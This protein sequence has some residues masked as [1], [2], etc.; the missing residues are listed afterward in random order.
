MQNL[1]KYLKIIIIIAFII[2]I[3]RIDFGIKNGYFESD[4]ENFKDSIGVYNK[5]A[6]VIFI[7][8][9][10]LFLFFK[11]RKQIKSK[12]PNKISPEYLK[13]TLLILFFALIIWVNFDTMTTDCSLII[14]KQKQ[15][16][17]VEREFKIDFYNDKKEELGLIEDRYNVELEIIEEHLEF[18]KLNKEIY[19]SLKDKKNI[20]LKFKTGLLGIPFEPEYKK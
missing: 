13:H 8:I 6:V 7:I 20:K 5:Y 18:Y 16:S 4:I 9:T 12:N 14:N 19:K 3:N 10:F 17:S 15:I 11:N 2:F 1:K